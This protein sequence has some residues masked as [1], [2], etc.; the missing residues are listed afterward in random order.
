VLASGSAREARGTEA[1]MGPRLRRRSTTGGKDAKPP[2][3]RPAE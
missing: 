3:P 1:R 2:A